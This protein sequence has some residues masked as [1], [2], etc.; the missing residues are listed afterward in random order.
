MQKV[1]KNK[2]LLE[3]AEMS[4]RLL[5][6]SEKTISRSTVKYGP[7]MDH[8]ENISNDFLLWERALNFMSEHNNKIKLQIFRKFSKQVLAMYVYIC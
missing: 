3:M 2:N 5:E 8:R 4:F 1:E 7:L 6:T